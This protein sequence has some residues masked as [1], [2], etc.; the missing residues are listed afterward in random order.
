MPWVVVVVALVG[1]LAL[2]LMVLAVMSK[3]VGLRPRA[4]SFGLGPK[5]AEPTVGGLRVELRPIPIGGSV[6]NEEQAEAGIG[7]R[8][9]PAVTAA[10]VLAGVG[11]LLLGVVPAVEVAVD[12]VVSVLRGALSPLGEAQTTIERVMRGIDAG[13]HRT[14]VGTAAVFL[15]V[16]NLLLGV[17][18]AVAGATRLTLAVVVGSLM[19]S[20]AWVVALVGYWV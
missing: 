12:S 8:L 14:T 15:G 17:T 11:V 1:C 6:D 18:H 4:V 3:V 20:V 13:E 16:W 5:L 2:H 9:V 7:A 19:L 10:L